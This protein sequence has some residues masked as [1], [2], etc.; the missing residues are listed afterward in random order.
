[1]VSTLQISGSD[2]SLRES[3]VWAPDRYRLHRKGLTR[4]FGPQA[5]D[6]PDIY[7]NTGQPIII[8]GS[9]ETGSYLLAGVAAGE[10][11]FFSTTHGSGR[12]MRYV[13]YIYC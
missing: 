6:L 5:E 7:K 4:D 2:V 1:M 12:T 8:G 13:G 11:T 10:Q 3:R 9:M